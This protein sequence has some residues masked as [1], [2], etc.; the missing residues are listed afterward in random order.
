M[1]QEA[2]FRYYWEGAHP[3]SGMIRESIPGDKRVVATGATGFGVMALLAGFERGFITRDQGI[4]RLT[5][6]ALDIIARQR[7]LHPADHVQ[8]RQCPVISLHVHFFVFGK[9]Q[10]PRANN[11][12]RVIGGDGHE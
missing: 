7:L 5:K 11:S 4:E 10:V 3:D 1:L 9:H 8:H 6:M 12:R 2:R